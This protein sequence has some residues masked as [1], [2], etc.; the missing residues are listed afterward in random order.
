MVKEVAGNLPERSV[1]KIWQDCLAGRTDL[2]T[3]EDGPIEVVYPGRPN[4]DRGADLCDAII[5]TGHG[6]RRGDVEIHVRSSSW[7]G[8]GHHRD[9]LYN[10]VILHVVFQRDTEAAATLQNGRRVPTLT[11]AKYITDTAGWDAGSYPLSRHPMPCRVMIDRRGPGFLGSILD[12]AGDQRFQARVVDFKQ[13]LS[14]AAAEPVLYQ[15]I[16][17]ALGY[18]KNKVPMLALARRLPLSRLSAAVPAEISD[19]ECL[20]R[21]QAL[22]LGTAGLLPSAKAGRCRES[23]IHEAWGDRLENAWAALGGTATMSAGDWHSFKVRPGNS[24]RRRLAAMSYLLCRFREEGLL[25]VLVREIERAAADVDCRGLKE[26]L[27][28]SAY[29]FWSENLD[30]G[31]PSHGVAPALLGENRAGVIVV[32]V[33]LP[34]AVAQGQA[35]SRPE[36]EEKAL[37]IYHRHPALAVNTLERHMRR[38]LGISRVLVNSARRQQGLIHIYKTLCSQGKC[39]DCPLS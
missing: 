25:P 11:L 19:D 21:Y 24:P 22:L 23:Y 15:G 7:W 32:N 27:L 20:V 33:L 12:M 4:D 34:F 14:Q 3:E 39:G 17:G 35:G 8:H 9:P 26:W 28:V 37:G 29:G 18:V 5:A 16:M 2:V 30:F 31:L 6:L 38:Q 13:Q 10:R 1:V 36:L